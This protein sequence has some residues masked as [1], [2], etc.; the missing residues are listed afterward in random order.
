MLVVPCRA[1]LRHQPNGIESGAF[2]ACHRGVN[3]FNR[4]TKRVQL[5]LRLHPSD[6]SSC[7][8]HPRPAPPSQ[9]TVLE[10]PNAHAQTPRPLWHALRPQ[11][12]LC[13]SVT[14]Q[15]TSVTISSTS[16]FDRAHFHY[17]SEHNSIQILMQYLL[18]PPILTA[19]NLCICIPPGIEQLTPSIYESTVHT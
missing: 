8:D 11:C 6:C 19:N 14:V 12:L 3:H 9:N 5:F 15:R 1:R 10:N 2:K 18:H 4:K 17:D 7:L 13:P 16:V